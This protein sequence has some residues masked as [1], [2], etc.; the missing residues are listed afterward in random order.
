MWPGSMHGSLI[1]NDCDLLGSFVDT[2]LLNGWLQGRSIS[3]RQDTGI[4]NNEPSNLRG[5]LVVEL[6]G[7]QG[8]SLVLAMWSCHTI[9]WSFETCHLNETTSRAARL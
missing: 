2:E 9:R 8:L 1:R 3:I 6:P 7:P 4:N 5:R